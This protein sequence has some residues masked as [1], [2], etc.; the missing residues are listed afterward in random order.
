MSYLVFYRNDGR[1]AVG[2]T[3]ETGVFRTVHSATIKPP[4]PWSI[5]VP[6]SGP[7]KTEFGDFAWPLL[8]FNNETSGVGTLRV[9][10]QASG[11]TALLSTA[12]PVF[13]L[14]HEWSRIIPV[15]D[16]HNLLFYRDDGRAA[17][18][19]FQFPSLSPIELVNTDINNNFTKNWS[20]IVPG[21]THLS[22]DQTQIL[23]YRND[24]RLAVGHIEAGTFVNT[25][26][27]TIEQN[28]SNVVSVL[29]PINVPGPKV[30]NFVFYRIDGTLMVAH[31]ESAPDHLV[32]T[33]SVTTFVPDVSMVV[34]V[35][36]DVL[37][38]R[39]DG[40]ATIGHI[41]NGKFVQTETI[42]NLTNNWSQIVTYGDFSDPAAFDT[43]QL[44]F[45]RNDGRAAVGHIDGTG[46]FV[47][48][49]AVSNFTSD[50]SLIVDTHY[51]SFS[52][53]S[54]QPH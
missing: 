1:F 18:A 5:I 53:A 6:I 41:E 47:N 20:H 34:P 17:V 15:D 4:S 54:V 14:T 27:T 24:G 45:Y 32:V 19:H 46:R 51:P 7:I 42:S 49:D 43:P 12:G 40:L 48:T 8:F 36:N 30:E 10:E 39:N 23:F 3:T 21:A 25:I 16:Q 26:S 33:D 2:D 29:Q 37:F 28:W 50:W 35:H 9:V 31:V 52:S 13:G 38:Y 11:S 44:L 22:G